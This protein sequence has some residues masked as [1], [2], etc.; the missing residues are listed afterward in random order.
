ME[1][2]TKLSVTLGLALIFA[3][4]LLYVWDPTW[5]SRPFGMLL[6]VIS[7][8]IAIILMQFY[9]VTRRKTQGIWEDEREEWIAGMTGYWFSAIFFPLTG[10]LFFVVHVTEFTPSAQEV[11]GILF[12]LMAIIR[13]SLYA[14]FKKTM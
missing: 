14:Y 6:G 10:I 12:G 1:K 8:V 2:D 9:I 5:V 11:L 7:M 4:V 3:G 13:F